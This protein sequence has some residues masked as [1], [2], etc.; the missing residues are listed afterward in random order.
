[1]SRTYSDPSFGSKKL[2]KGLDAGYA[3]N[4]TNASNTTLVRILGGATSPLSITGLTAAQTTIG[5]QAIANALVLNTHL[6]GTGAAV[7]IGTV[8]LGTA[9]EVLAAGAVVDG[10]VTTTSIADGDALSVTLVA[11]TETAANLRVVPIVEY[12]EKFVAASE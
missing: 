1:M 4:G 6:A 9:G 3:I 8:T 5:T 11:G 12:T 7:A 10:T 2:L